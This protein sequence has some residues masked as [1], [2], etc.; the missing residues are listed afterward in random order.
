MKIQ[1]NIKLSR[2]IVLAFILLLLATCDTEAETP[3]PAPTATA[4][5]ALAATDTAGPPSETPT[6]EPTEAPPTDTPT[7]APTE[8]PL[9]TPTPTP[10]PL[11][12]A[13]AATVRIVVEGS[14]FLETVIGSG[15]GVLY[16]EGGLILTSNHLVD[17]AGLIQVSIE[18]RE[19]S[20]TAQ[21]VGRSACDNVAVLQLLG[22]D[23]PSA[24]MSED[25]SLD[26][27]VQ[28]IGYPLG[29]TN[30]STQESASDTETSQISAGFATM[31]GTV[32]LDTSLDS[33][34]SGAPVLTGD[35]LFS[36]LVV[37]TG[38][39][40]TH[41]VVSPLST[42]MPLLA[43][44]EAGTNLNWIGV[45]AGPLSAD[46]A[47]A[48]GIETEPG[49]F[50]YAV[51][52]RGPGGQAD[53]RN[54]D[55]ITEIGGVDVTGEDSLEQYCSVLRENPEGE[56]LD[57]VVRRDDNNYLGQLYGD[58]LEEEVIVV[59]ETE[60]EAPAA[61]GSQGELLA[62]IQNTQAELNNIG[63]T[64]DSLAANGCLGQ[65][66]L[67][68][69]DGPMNASPEEETLAH[70]GCIH[71]ISDCEIIVAAY[72]RIA[73]PPGVNVNGADPLMVNANATHQ[74]AISTFVNGAAN[75]VEACRAFIGDPNL[76]IGP[77][78]FGLARQ[79]VSDAV[80]MLIPAIQQLQG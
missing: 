69:G 37:Y 48:L 31:T 9:P 79:A 18:G 34:F 4:E 7:P 20:L 80:N 67:A 22:S 57:I 32:Q 14:E 28:I 64:I 65:P 52:F 70:P 56:A 68:A 75:L 62:V 54:G 55:V 45:N 39:E 49:L 66:L 71:S 47:E 43:E 46:S 21:I 50:V 13:Q 73:N 36:G 23:F 25:D 12:L 19:E 40:N 17:G 30:Q 59:E 42:I 29:E 8:T 11:E 35:G 78:A 1:N 41:A 53:I 76:S 58:P 27:R 51:D 3:T 2:F 74:A 44:L 77:L 63:G 72:G 61:G 16:D 33:G 5:V 26:G 15:T 10:S 6:A 60:E 38:S 24:T